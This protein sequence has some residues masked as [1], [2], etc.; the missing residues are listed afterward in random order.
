MQWLR[1]WLAT[2]IYSWK[3]EKLRSRDLALQQKC[4]K[5]AECCIIQLV[6]SV[7]HTL[8][9][10]QLGNVS[11]FTVW[12]II[13]EICP[14]PPSPPQHEIYHFYQC[15]QCHIILCQINSSQLKNQHCHFPLGNPRSPSCSWTFSVLTITTDI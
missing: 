3:Y 2:V 4:T 10:E 6:Y 15:H 13:S 14:P 11:L 8:I 9:K 12:Y 7:L 5:R 1:N